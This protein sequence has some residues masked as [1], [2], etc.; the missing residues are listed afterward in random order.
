[1]LDLPKDVRKDGVMSQTLRRLLAAE[2]WI[3]AHKARRH[4]IDA[5]LYGG[6]MPAIEIFSEATIWSTA[7]AVIHDTTQN[8]AVYTRQTA[9]AI[10]QTIDFGTFFPVTGTYTV[11]VLGTTG[12]SRGLLTFSLDGVAIA[13]GTMDFYA[14]VGSQNVYKTI[15]LTIS[16]VGYH[17]LRAVITKNAASSNYF[18]EF[19]KMTITPASY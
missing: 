16:L 17:K 11:S 13:G 8:Y 3:R 18:I 7:T 14:A 6:K 4:Q 5:D 15:S 9:P 19:T 1:M 10:N 2:E 12:T